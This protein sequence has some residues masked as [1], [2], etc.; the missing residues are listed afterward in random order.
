MPLLDFDYMKQDFRLT[1]INK[2]C[3]HGFKTRSGNESQVIYFWR[4]LVILGREHEE[5]KERNLEEL[6]LVC[7]GVELNNGNNTDTP[8]PESGFGVREDNDPNPRRVDFGN[9]E[10][11]EDFRTFLA[12]G[13]GGTQN[14][15]IPEPRNSLVAFTRR[16]GGHASGGGGPC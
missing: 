1:C 16:F 7:A 14:I 13:S 12:G 3:S 11:L 4:R 15:G 10:V 9:I 2:N 5:T 6:K 8:D